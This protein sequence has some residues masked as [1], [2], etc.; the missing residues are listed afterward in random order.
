LQA[1]YRRFGS[2]T[3]VF[4]IV[5]LLA[6]GWIALKKRNSKS[7]V[8]FLVL[9]SLFPIYNL[10][11]EIGVRVLQSQ[12]APSPE[13]MEVHIKE[14][15]RASVFLLVYD[16]MTDLQTLK[17]LG[18]NQAPLAQILSD[19]DFKVY[20]NTY[21]I[22]GSSVLSMGKTYD[23]TDDHSLS[24]R[25]HVEACA[26][27]GRSFRIFSLNSYGTNNIQGTYM[28]GGNTFTDDFFPPKGRYS[29]DVNS[30]FVLLQGIFI[31]E[32]RFDA[33]GLISFTDDDFHK[34]LREK[35]STKKGAWFTAMHVDLPGHSQNGVLRPNE[36]EL[37]IERYDRVLPEIREDIEAILRN[38]PS[39]IIVIIGDHGPRLMEWSEDHKRN[40]MGATEVM[41]RD[42][43]G[44]LV[45]IHWPDPDRAAKYDS[46]LFVNQDIFPVVFAYLADSEEPLK[47]MI[48]NKQVVIEDRI[49]L[50]NGKF[51]KGAAQK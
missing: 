19:N 50:D 12:S 16:A 18:V 41:I 34:F 47:M 20:P 21:S 9:S 8:F 15:E 10:F 26:G 38:K 17:A 33:V 37:F 40:S 36:T 42:L 27:D 44:T 31:G 11:G 29:N 22:E 25:R 6:A 14:D 45:A 5:F 13:L 49:F 39:S 28:T 32:F 51:I 23:I 7:V 3:L 4:A 2:P 35:A 43:Y 46:D 24:R 30:L 48:K 1:Y